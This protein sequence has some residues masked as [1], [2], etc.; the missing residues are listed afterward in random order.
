MDI[1][2][3]E[4]FCKVIELK[5]FTKAAEWAML[6][7]PTVSEHIRSL[8]QQ[9][10]QQLIDRLG[11]TVEVTPVGRL[12][13]GY[14]L[15]L[16]RLQE[17][18]L[19]AVERFSG[20]LAGR[21]ILGSSTIPGTYILPRLLAAL[22]KAH[23][24]IQADLNIANSRATARKVMDGS[25]DLGI[26]GARWNDR[27]LQW[28]RIYQDRLTLAVPP[29]SPL[30]ARSSVQVED[31][32]GH[33]FILREPGSGTRKMVARILERKGCRENDLQKVTVI[34]STAAV[35]EAIKAGLGISILSRRALSEDIDRATI[36]GLSLED[37]AMERP[38]YLIQRKNRA[39]TPVAAAFSALLLRDAE[40]T[41]RPPLSEEP[42]RL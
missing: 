39:L 12:F 19:Q 9:L 17:E 31:L 3:L 10:G 27:S 22:F 28:T 40:L 2:K 16:I 4:V 37:D 41:S 13:Y 26:V 36:I 6:S 18:S 7:Q 25:Y 5:S 15:K 35:K 23:P 24:D 32:L 11:R 42:D 29:G 30:T 34:G 20:H 38:F 21:V 33:P 14:A 8:E 1:R